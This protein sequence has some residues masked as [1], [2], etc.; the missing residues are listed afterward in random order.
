M[1]V[2]RIDVRGPHPV[3]IVGVI[4]ITLR[5]A[6]RNIT[7]TQAALLIIRMADDGRI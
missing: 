2:A 4:A 5:N 7:P 3:F 6:P 1:P